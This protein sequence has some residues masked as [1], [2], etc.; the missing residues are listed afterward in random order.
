M[1][2]NRGPL[3]GIL[4]ACGMRSIYTA[5]RECQLTNSFDQMPTELMIFS[6]ALHLTSLFDSKPYRKA[7]STS[8]EFGGISYRAVIFKPLLRPINEVMRTVDYLIF[9][10]QLHLS[11][12]K[13]LVGS[14]RTHVWSTERNSFRNIWMCPFES[15]LMA[16]VQDSQCGWLLK[17][18]A[19]RT[20][21]M[22]DEVP[23]TTLFGT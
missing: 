1:T 6:S 17:R 21:N 13:A 23:E 20:I 7:V 22:W 2:C 19:C 3:P 16:E 8:D 9:L 14:Y 4:Q 5:T 18:W 10:Y 15:S 11:S 12:S